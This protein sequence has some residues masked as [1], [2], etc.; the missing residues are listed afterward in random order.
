MRETTEVLHLRH[1][2]PLRGLSVACPAGT[3]TSIKLGKL[4]SHLLLLKKN[5]L[6]IPADC[7][8]CACL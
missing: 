5:Q 6:N 2:G 8:V 7:L 1:P 3:L 4:N